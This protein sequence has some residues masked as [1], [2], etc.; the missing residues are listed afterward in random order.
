MKSYDVSV[1]KKS[2]FVTNSCLYTYFY[3]IF[4]PFSAATQTMTK[5]MTTETKGWT[6]G[7]ARGDCFSPWWASWSPTSSASRSS[8]S[9][10][11][12]APSSATSWRALQWSATAAWYRSW[13]E[14]V[15]LWKSK[16]LSYSL[17]GPIQ[18]IHVSNEDT[19]ICFI[20]WLS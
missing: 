8:W 3:L 20:T 5:T 4:S 10:V 7:A 13:G 6:P 18:W 17:R 19:F 1:C 12:W 14:G 2:W 16:G 11:C 9:T 15:L